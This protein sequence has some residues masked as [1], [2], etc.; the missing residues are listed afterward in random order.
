MRYL[1]A[2]LLLAF[3]AL[4][5]AQN[6]FGSLRTQALQMTAGSNPLFMAGTTEGLFVSRDEMQSWRPVALSPDLTRPQPGITQIDHDPF[7]SSV[8]Y[9]AGSERTSTVSVTLNQRPEIYRSDDAGETWN[10][11]TS[12]LP[13]DAT[14][15]AIHVMQNAQG[16]LYAYLHVND[17][18]RVY[19]SA[20][21]GDSWTLFRTLPSGAGPLLI[22]PRNPNLWYYNTGRAVFKSVNAGESWA[23]AGPFPLRSTGGGIEN[24]ITSTILDPNNEGILVMCTSGPSFGNDEVN[25]GIFF[26]NTQG[27]SWQRKTTTIAQ[28]L[29]L[30][31]GLLLIHQVEGRNLWISTDS[32]RSLQQPVRMSGGSRRADGFLIDR[33]ESD[34]IYSG[35]ELSQDRGRNWVAREAAVTPFFGPDVPSIETSG[36]TNDQAPRILTT[37]VIARG[38]GAWALPFTVE[39]S[40]SWLT[41]TSASGTT[42]ASI[43]VRI[44]AGG[45]PVGMHEA[46]LTFRSTE[47]A[48]SEVALPVR[49]TVTAEP[50]A[51]PSPTILTFALDGSFSDAGDGGP[52]TAASMQGP[53]FMVFNAEGGL[54]I[55]D[56]FA[57]KVRYI[58]PA[59]VIST[60]AGTG[61]GEFGGDGGPAVQARI[62]SPRGL[63]VGPMGQVYIADGFNRRVRLV[64][65]D[66]RIS[67]V[68]G[69]GEL[70]SNAAT[71]RAADL[72]ISPNDIIAT[73][74]GGYY[75]TGSGTYRV[76]PDGSYIRWSLTSYTALALGPNGRLYGLTSNRVSELRPNNFTQPYAGTGSTGFSGDGGPALEA[77]LSGATDMI[78]DREG[79]LFIADSG[80]HV[81]RMVDRNGVIS[82]Y[83]GTGVSGD[84]GD[85]GPANLAQLRNPRG[86]IVGPDDRLY[87]S[88]GGRIRV[89]LAP[90]EA[91]PGPVLSSAGVVSA[92]SFTNSVVAP[93]QIVSIFGSNLSSEVAEATQTPLPETLAGTRSELIDASGA[94]HRLSFVF[95]SPGQINAVVPGGVAA[96]AA[97]LRVISAAGQAGETTIQVAAV[98]PGLF[99]VDARGQGLA[100]AAAVRVASDG[101]QTTVDVLSPANPLAAAPI[102]LGPDGDLVVLLLFGTGMRNFSS[103]IKVT[104]GGLPATIVGFGPSTEFVGL[105]QLTAVIPRDL[106]GRGEVDV[107]VEV[108]G[109]AANTVTITVQ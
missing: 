105:A 58:N 44:N 87:I 23:S 53:T 24:S 97:R 109:Q 106:A 71:G 2:P 11:K 3:A 32:G 68:A 13:E 42:P 29:Y 85:G 22:H 38:A 20:N 33:R 8:F 17:E 1:T 102:N 103:E 84:S 95:V 61:V 52:A 50:A 57:D 18:R 60:F 10:R 90:G 63:S 19:R 91:A 21:R 98:A 55:S 41:T 31:E 65:P 15:R 82:T 34:T 64:G 28:Q 94:T 96:G 26:S 62:D 43:S 51:D 107:N 39:S 12:G 69:T 59:G 66:G 54:Y 81:V 27:A 16:V 83:A 78:F 92:A 101:A 76:N 99:S 46:T 70:G 100:A 7:S 72:N 5:P 79:R 108:D 86:V 49:L 88:G 56:Q 74:D 47:A 104:I 40:A 4:M 77:Q 30:S 35:L 80:N 93:D 67:T 14:L 75:M 37:R 6:D 45:V 36:S 25:N 89:V 48:N 73:P 9:A